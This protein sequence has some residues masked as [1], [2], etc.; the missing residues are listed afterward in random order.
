MNLILRIGNLLCLFIGFLG[1][2]LTY[3][4]VQ[5]NSDFLLFM[6]LQNIIILVPSLSLMIGAILVI[7]YDYISSKGRFS[8]A[9]LLTM[10]VAG[11]SFYV[12]FKDVY[13]YIGLSIL[14]F[15]L[16][17]IVTMYFYICLFFRYFINKFD[18]T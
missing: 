3:Q 1:F 13:S 18:K 12:L 17:L 4:G 7:M 15:E 10:S 6:D 16:F 8:S 2:T 9:M 5:A 14:G 11:T